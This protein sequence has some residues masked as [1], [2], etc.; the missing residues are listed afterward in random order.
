MCLTSLCLFF[1]ASYP[2][3]SLNSLPKRFFALFC[4]FKCLYPVPWAADG[5]PLQ[6]AMMEYT[7]TSL[8]F[9]KAD[10]L[11]QIF[12]NKYRTINFP[13]FQVTSIHNIP[14]I[15]HQII[16]FSCP[17]CCGNIWWQTA[18]KK[19]GKQKILIINIKWQKRVDFP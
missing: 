4:I 12:I 5:Q 3:A 1:L 13:P 9:K 7:L 2:D 8:T 18:R 17:H 6:G 15:Y 11:T 19:I 14:I 10:F 16:R